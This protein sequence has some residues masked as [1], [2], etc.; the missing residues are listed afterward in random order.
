MSSNVGERQPQSL[1]TAAATSGSIPSW[2]KV[3][4]SP[5]QSSP[6]SAPTSSIESSSAPNAGARSS[7]RSSLDTVP[8]LFPVVAAT[9][10]KSVVET[11]SDRLFI[12][13]SS[14]AA[15]RRARQAAFVQTQVLS[16]LFSFVRRV[17]S[18]LCSG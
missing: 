12:S 17:T 14:A 8:A 5:V 9:E 6:S 3:E 7:R 1:A 11:P 18:P 10:A 16:L 2:L 15:Q 13:E 4:T